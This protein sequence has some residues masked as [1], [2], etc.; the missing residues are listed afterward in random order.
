MS[1]EIHPFRRVTR[2]FARNNPSINLSSTSSIVSSATIQLEQQSDSSSSSSSSESSDEHSL[3]GIT[4]PPGLTPPGSPPVPPPPLQSAQTFESDDLFEFTSLFDMPEDTSKLPQLKERMDWFTWLPSI[5]T[6]ATTLN[7][8]QYIDPEGTDVAENPKPPAFKADGDKELFRMQGA[9]YNVWQAINSKIALVRT[10]IESTIPGFT[11]AIEG[12]AETRECIMKLKAQVNPEDRDQVQSIRDTFNR[13]TQGPE[14]GKE[15]AWMQ[16][17][18]KITVRAETLKIENMSESQLCMAFID[19]SRTVNPSFYQMMKSK[20]VPREDMTRVRSTMET[21][22][23]KLFDTIHSYLSGISSP[24]AILPSFDAKAYLKDLKSSIED[25]QLTMNKIQGLFRSHMTQGARANTAFATLNSLSNKRGHS[26]NDEESPERPSKKTSRECVCGNIHDYRQC[27]YLFPEKAP[28]GWTPSQQTETAIRTKVTGTKVIRYGLEKLFKLCK[29][30][31]PDFLK[32]ALFCNKA[33]KSETKPKGKTPRASS[34]PSEAVAHATIAMESLDVD[35]NGDISACSSIST[36]FMTSNFSKNDFQKMKDQFYADSAA[37]RH[38]CNNVERF[39]TFD[40]DFVKEPV[41]FGDTS[42]TALAKGTVKIAIDKPDGRI[43]TLIL[44]DVLYVPNFLTNLIS[45]AKLEDRGIYWD[46]ESK[47]LWKRN[48]ETRKKI[49]LAQG[50]RQNGMYLL[51]SSSEQAPQYGAAV[52]ATQGQYSPEIRRKILRGSRNSAR[53]Y[54]SK[55]S[56]DIWHDRMGH[57]RKEALLHLPEAV[58]GVELTSKHF[59][60][61]SEL[62]E[63]CSLGHMTQVINRKPVKPPPYAFHTVHFDV[64]PFNPDKEDASDKDGRWILH[65]MDPYSGYHTAYTW[66]GRKTQDILL[67]WFKDFLKR[68][69]RW[70]FKIQYFQGDNEPVLKSKWDHFLQEHGLTFKPSAPDTQSQNGFAERAGRS[71]VTI[72]RKTCIQTKL[73]KRLWGYFI[74]SAVRTLNEAPI[75]RKKWTTPHEIVHGKKPDC[76]GAR[77]PGSLAYI[78]RKGK[79]KLRGKP[80]KLDKLDE[81][82]IKGWYLGR[83][84]SNIFEIWVPDVDLVIYARDVLI[85][86]GVRYTPDMELVQTIPIE[87]TRTE[88]Q[89]LDLYHMYQAL[90]EQTLEDEEFH[91][92]AGTFQT[93]QRD[94]YPTPEPMNEQENEENTHIDAFEALMASARDHVE[95]PTPDPTDDEADE[96]PDEVMT[97]LKSSRAQAFC[98][99]TDPRGHAIAAFMAAMRTKPERR[100]RAD[101]PAPPLNW[102]QMKKH[103]FAQ[104]F[105]GAA[106]K[107]FQDLWAKDTFKKVRLSKEEAK[108]AIPLKWVFTDKFNENS[109]HDKHKARI[110][111]RGDLQKDP[112]ND[113]YAATGAYRTF[114]MLLALVAA[115]DLDLEQV[116]VTNAFVNALL[117]DIVYVQYPDGFKKQQGEYLQLLRALYGLKISPKLWF[118][119]C[120][121]KLKELGFSACVDEPCL[122]I[123]KDTGVIIFFYVD[124]FLIASPKSKRAEVEKLKAELDTTYGIRDFGP[125]KHF[126]NVRILRDRKQRKLWILQ[127]EYIIKMVNKFHLIHSKKVHTPLSSGIKLTPCLNPKPEH[128]REYQQKTGSILHSAVVSRPD[129]AFAASYLS[130]FNTKCTLEHIREADRVIAYL[131]HTRY[132]SIGWSGRLPRDDYIFSM[133]TMQKTAEPVLDIHGDSSYADDPETRRSTQGFLIKLFN[134][135]IAWQSSKQKTVVTSTTEAELLALSTI[136][137][138]VI[139]MTRL[140]S[141]ISFDPEEQPVIKCDNLQTVGIVT[142]ERSPYAS[143]LRHIDIHQFW[144][145]Q[146]VQSGKVLIQ[147]VPTAEMKAD[148]LTKAKGRIPH[149]EFVAQLGLDDLVLDSMLTTKQTASTLTADHTE[150]DAPQLE[151]LMAPDGPT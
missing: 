84:A 14:K 5:K 52:F 100:K 122:L 148:G 105:H 49:F 107:E 96:I 47:C 35:S 115:F 24:E 139:A 7:V 1:S 32:D 85:D 15:E 90:Y 9:H 56:L 149:K 82:S 131:Y 109:D 106:T 75:Q 92:Q 13:L 58:D 36:A 77:I 79:S 130:Q 60:R 16:L 128:V 73:P 81:V 124:D 61:L 121:S 22:M 46:S 151:D 145:R 59:E 110:C 118:E 71:I 17:W 38:F 89:D 26:D 94:S 144:L 63:V 42:G 21:S 104:G 40:P 116:D 76:S 45:T 48:S 87:Q 69:E 50:R 111:V 98:T 34:D 135:P 31:I 53:Q 103:P 113:L 23:Q 57:I 134:G 93:I 91:D 78:L 102:T 126:L 66:G 119:E 11:F 133:D 147:W 97:E 62:C 72:A 2:I 28:D 64:I 41:A 150:E 83:S 141:Q 117:K 120:S 55:A 8:W 12:V 138:E 54:V 43:G 25:E 86:E 70:G 108:N 132:R 33:N 30:R 3:Y 88:L 114:R 10:R 137:K 18:I 51:E 44:R 142:K 65:L 143:K 127:D 123:N 19:A 20:A 74:K 68:T 140:F 39:E 136:A 95:A 101:M 99:R 129:I 37:N 112:G 80:G 4:A 29:E 27:W 146:E 125:A 6:Y 67:C